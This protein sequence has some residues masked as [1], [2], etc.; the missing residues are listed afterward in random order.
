MEIRKQKRSCVQFFYVHV[1]THAL[2][3]SRVPPREGRG[4]DK[5]Q[6]M[7]RRAA[8]SPAP[9]SSGA[10]RSRY[11]R[12]VSVPVQLSRACRAVL[13]YLLPCHYILIAS[14]GLGVILR[15]NQPHSVFVCA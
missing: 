7:R 15:Y 9:P 6:E 1:V 13:A 4:F 12:Y 14:A 8:V 2:E 11:I 3:V 10:A 5:L